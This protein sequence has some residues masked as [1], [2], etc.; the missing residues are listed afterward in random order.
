MTG[1]S[2][3]SKFYYH[4]RSSVNLATCRGAKE[5]IEMGFKLIILDNQ[6]IERQQFTESN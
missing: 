3:T 6:A 5:F 1:E 2:I 4:F